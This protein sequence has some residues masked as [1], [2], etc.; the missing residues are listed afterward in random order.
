MGELHFSRCTEWPWTWDIPYIQPAADGGYRVSGP[1]RSEHVGPTATAREA[2]A[3]VVERLLPAADPPSLEPRKNSRPTKPRPGP[4]SPVPRTPATVG[5]EPFRCRDRHPDH[6]TGPAPCPDGHADA[7]APW[8]GTG[9]AS[10]SGLRRARVPVDAVPQPPRADGAG[11][12]PPDL[13]TSP[14]PSPASVPAARTGGPPRTG[15]RRRPGGRRAGDGRWRPTAGRR[16][17]RRRPHGPKTPVSRSRRPG[18]TARWTRRPRTPPRDGR[19]TG[20]P[21]VKRPWPRRRGSR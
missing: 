6:G 19:E 9:G 7:P 18:T 21:L 14:A 13:H 10:P 2:I 17:S 3:M 5:T 11:P 8:P 15:L 1:R 12:R 4:C 16:R 20:P